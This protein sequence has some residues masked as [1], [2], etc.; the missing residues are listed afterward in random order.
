MIKRPEN[1]LVLSPATYA[2]RAGVSAAAV[3]IAVM[4][5]P[6]FAQTTPATPVDSAQI[7]SASGPEVIQDNSD[8]VVTGTLLRGVAPVGTNV[9]GLNR[10]DILRSGVASANDLLADIPQVGNFGTLP[11]GTGSFALPVVRPNIRNLAAAGGSSTLVLLNGHRMVGAG[12]LQT[13]VDPSILPPEVID[14]VEIVPD[15]GSAIYGSDAIGG[16]VNFITRRRFNGLAA[17]VRYG[18]ADD[19]QTV[20]ASLTAGKDWGSGS[21]LLTYAYAWHDNI[22]NRDRAYTA[23]DHTARGGQDFRS[24]VCPGGNFTDLFTGLT[25]AGPTFT[26]GSVKKCDS[27]AYSDLYPREERN[28]VFASLTQQLSDAIEFSATAYWSRRDTTTLSQTPGVSG[29]TNITAINPFFRPLGPSPV[30]LVSLS[31]DNV[32]G[33]TMTSNARF[34]SYGVTPG[35]KV[36][37]GKDWQVRAEANVGRSYNLVLENTINT[38]AVDA[39]L[40]SFN[41][42][43]ALNPY[44][45]SATNP[46]VLAKIGNFQ[47]YGRAIQELAEARVVV[48]GSLAELPGGNVR[49]AVGAEYHYENL[50]SQIS[51]NPRGVFTNSIASFASRNVKSAFGELLIPIFGEGNGGPGMRALSLSGSVRY[52]DYSDNGG[53]TN[54]KVGF[55]YKPVDQLT[56]RGN[57][58]TSFHAPSLA[59]T[60]STSDSRAQILQISP[61]RAQGSLPTDF[62]RPTII[63]AGGNPA[64]KPERANT[65]SL[66]FDWKPTI[67]PGLVVSAT[68]YNVHFKDAI[69]VPPLTS[70]VLFSNPGYASYYI[71]N[72]TL[73]Q[74]LAKVGNLLLNGA[75]SIQSLYGPT[76]T[77]YVLIDARRSN[78]GAI[79]VDGIDFNINYLRPTGFG[80]INLGVSG[81]YT[82]NRTNQAVKGD[83]FIDELKNGTGRLAMVATAGGKV[84]DFTA[85]AKLNY[86]QGFPILGLGAQKRVGAF[87]PV[88]LFFSYALPDKGV[89]K[90]TLLTLNVDNV[91]DRDPPYADIQSGYTNGGTIGRLVSV[92]LRKKF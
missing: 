71:I 3:A 84:G 13:T 31:F 83:P 4:A 17:N 7:D 57:Y 23:A 60:T 2:F 50:A 22:Q 92:G 48:D 38:G 34:E 41:P 52:D 76:I 12:V 82:L 55:T 79:K 58:G 65:W 18:F 75:S 24:T 69:Q 72:P 81:T 35:F 16:V 25:F 62:N 64:L 21:L 77:P 1:N 6:A 45:L 53:T 73:A 67:V 49:L 30:Q 46:A 37:I 66:G 86:R 32:F 68:Y 89:L 78:I 15:G 42:A 36:D 20:D 14:R 43:T 33:P 10:D 11:V 63:L 28:T 61:F 59:D 44:N 47:N 29:T 80:S 39:A 54:P 91:F 51:F 56:I 88:D 74:S 40:A 85:Q 26:P 5:G 9:V 70:P 87:A 8:I 27:S 90:G 19:Y